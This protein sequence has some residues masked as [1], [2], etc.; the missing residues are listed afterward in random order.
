MPLWKASV[1][2][3]IFIVPIAFQKSVKS[4]KFLPRPFWKLKQK[5]NHRK[6]FSVC[7]ESTL[8]LHELRSLGN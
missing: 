6:N 8:E 7:L 3:T 5:L 1:E 2:E 4:L